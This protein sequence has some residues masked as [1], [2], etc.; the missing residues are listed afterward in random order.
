MIDDVFSYIDQ[1]AD[2]YTERLRA[3]CQQPSIAAQN[4]G[5]I[6]RSRFAC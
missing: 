3:L 6:S 4:L 5:I 1:H 2:A